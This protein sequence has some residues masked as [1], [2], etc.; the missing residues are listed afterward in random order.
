MEREKEIRNEVV[1]KNNEVS[2]LKKE[3]STLERELRV[4][5]F[6]YDYKD[7]NYPKEVEF[8]IKTILENEP[9]ITSSK[10][11]LEEWSKSDIED[12]YDFSYTGKDLLKRTDSDVIA[13]IEKEIFSKL[14]KEYKVTIDTTECF[15]YGIESLKLTISLTKT[16]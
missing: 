13:S 12:Y 15:Q 6:Q 2:I 9:S 5:E 7:S 8:F 11:I 3:I 16:T 10:I 1:F 4:L 14:K